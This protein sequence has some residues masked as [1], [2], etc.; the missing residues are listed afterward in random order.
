[1]N[2]M[3]RFVLPILCVGAILWPPGG[4][5]AGEPASGATSA[6][7]MPINTLH[8]GRAALVDGDVKVQLGKRPPEVLKVGDPLLPRHW[9]ITGP[10]SQVVI[11]FR[12]GST[13]TAGPDAKVELKQFAFN[14][15]ESQ[16]RKVIQVEQ[17]AYRYLSGFAVKS[18]DVRINTATAT[19][20]IRGSA[21]EGLVAAGLPDFVNVSNGSARLSNPK[22]HAMVKAGQAIAA[23]SA[24]SKAA[25]GDPKDFSK[26]VAAQTVLFLQKEL[27]KTHPTLPP[28][29]PEQ[30]L[31]DA[32]ANRLPI[33]AQD[34]AKPGAAVMEGDEPILPPPGKQSYLRERLEHWWRAAVQGMALI[35]A[36]EAATP[37][38]IGQAVAL[39]A[40]AASLGM[41]GRQAGPMTTAQQAFIARAAQTMPQAAA[42]LQGNA[43]AQQTANTANAEAGTRAVVSGAA[44]VATDAREVA[45]IVGAAVQAAGQQ[46]V[47]VTTAIVQSAMSAA[48]KTNTAAAATQIVAAAAKANPA[49]AAQ[50]AVEAIKT[51]P[52]PPVGMFA[53]GVEAVIM[54][55]RMQIAAAAAAAVPQSAAAVAAAVTEIAGPAAAGS[56]AAAVTQ[57]AT[58]AATA[59]AVAAG[60][61]PAAIAGQMAAQVAGAVT[62]KAGGQAARVAAALVA[63]NPGN[64]AIAAQVAGAV[65]ANAGAQAAAQV[66][67]VVVRM[68]GAQAAGEIAGAVAASIKGQTAGADGVAAAGLVAAA[69]AQVATSMGADAT[70]VELIN[71]SVANG[72]AIVQAAIENAVANVDQAQ[73]QQNAAAIQDTVAQAEQTAQDSQQAAEAVNDAVEQANEVVT[74]TADDTTTDDVT[75]ETDNPADDTATE[76]ADEQT[77]EDE[78]EVEEETEE[79]D[80]FEEEED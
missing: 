59:A 22:G 33:A 32:Q 29:T 17:G 77:E 37:E 62:A 13:F 80:P 48:D 72:M 35:E 23:P 51:L 54:A 28:F 18:S 79:E 49:I 42:I 41:I 11:K 78:T 75:E 27:G 64:S 34:G 43:T 58:K 71:S 2:P 25:P 69:V 10:S 24:A 76:G 30:L 9:V 56:I 6:G 57:A 55:S 66:A 67:S 16:A 7:K 31:A 46:G 4:A 65:T 40:E 15:A 38:Q 45:Q 53:E 52:A 36:A 73:L 74:D 14:P 61:D 8:L 20:G 70:A 19:M 5:L 63:L 26:E 50:A 1:M 68:V 44:Q 12:D 3:R 39:L 47:N 21:V 60:T